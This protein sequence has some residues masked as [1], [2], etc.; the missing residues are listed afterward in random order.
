MIRLC[1]NISYSGRTEIVIFDEDHFHDAE[2]GILVQISLN[3]KLHKR[4]AIKELN[5]LIDKSDVK[6]IRPV[7]HAY[8]FNLDLARSEISALMKYDWLRGMVNVLPEIEYEETELFGEPSTETIVRLCIYEE[9][10]LLSQNRKIFLSHK[11]KNKPTIRQFNDTLRVIG[12][13]TWLDEDLMPAGTEFERG[14]LKGMQE[15]CAAVFFITPDFVDK[16]FLATE[17]DYAISEK[18]KK[19]E[20]FSIITMVLTG[21]NGER[22]EVPDLLKRYVWKEPDSDLECLQ[23]IIKALPIKMAGID[24]KV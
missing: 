2:K 14:L 11:G 17:I 6:W 8:S 10:F 3:E 15:S 13:E 19:K 24:W 16:D 21:E 4:E 20:R 18:R 23:E 22:G 7:S 9:D 5:K 1:L 12:F